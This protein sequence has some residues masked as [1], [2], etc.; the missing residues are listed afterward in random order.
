MLKEVSFDR[1]LMPRMVIGSAVLCIFSDASKEAFGTCAY[2]RLEASE[3]SYDVR[4]VAAKIRIAN[5]RLSSEVVQV[6]TIGIANT[7]R[8]D[9]LLY[10]QSNCIYL[11]SSQS[12]AFKPSVSVRV[13]EIQSKSNPC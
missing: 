11:D 6:D 3:K 12:R 4:F 7:V 1:S 2:L 13:G 5:S 9:H 10:G 8:K